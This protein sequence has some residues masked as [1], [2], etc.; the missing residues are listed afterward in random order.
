MS[1]IKQMTQD[2]KWIVLDWGSQFV[3]G[4]LKNTAG[5]SGPRARGLVVVQHFTLLLNQKKLV[6]PTIKRVAFKYIEND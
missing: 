1:F 2:M 3:S 4:L 5:K 6:K